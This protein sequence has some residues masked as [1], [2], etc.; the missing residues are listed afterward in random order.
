MLLFILLLFVIFFT[1]YYKYGSKEGFTQTIPLNLFQTWNT[2]DLPPKMKACVY[3][4]R[5]QNPEFKYQLYDD[6]DC[7]K[8]LKE[9]FDRDVVYA[10]HRLKP[11]AYKA[12]LWRYCVLY[13]HG[14]M[15]LDIK[16]E[17]CDGFKCI[18]LMDKEHYVMDRQ[19]DPVTGAHFAEKGKILVYNGCMVSP[20]KNPILLKCIQKIVKNVKEEEYGFNPLYPTG[21]GLLGEVLGKNKNIDLSF[22]DNQQYIL[23]K[24]KRILKKYKEYRQEQRQSREGNHYDDLWKDEDIYL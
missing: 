11:G 20:A 24:K 7:I 15:Y 12:D 21:P 19:K 14:G 23:Y 10:F 13:V 1:L 6:E 3:R 8:L 2:K 16:F 18:E 17:C 4:L 9:N 22:S 5:Q